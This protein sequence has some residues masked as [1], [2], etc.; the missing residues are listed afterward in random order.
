MRERV[1]IICLTVIVWGGVARAADRNAKGESVVE[2][3]FT[4]PIF[5]SPSSSSPVP[6][7]SNQTT[8]PKP[9]APES[10][11]VPRSFFDTAAANDPFAIP[12]STQCL[13]QRVN[14]LCRCPLDC[15]TWFS[16]EWLIG[17][18]RGVSLVPVIT[19]GPA[20]AG[21]LAGAVGQPTTF[22]LFGGKQVLN[23]WRSG[24]RVELGVWFDPDHRSGVSVRFY[25]L[26]SERE[27]FTALPNG[28]EVV[29]VPHFV[30]VGSSATQIP[31]FVGFPGV[32]SGTATASAQTTFTGGD[33]NYRHLLDGDDGHR[34]ELLVGYR[35]LYLSDQLGATFTAVPM[36]LNSSLATRLV[37]GDSLH[38]HNDFYGPQLG[39]CASTAWNRFTLEAHATTALGVTV[40]DLDFTRART[41]NGGSALVGIP[42]TGT[43]PFAANRIPLGAIATNGTLTYFG[44][45]AEGGVRLNW[46][47][48]DRVRL[49]GGYSFIYW[50]DV[51]RA[52][53]MFTGSSVL[54]AHSVDSVT[55]LLS[56]GLE[57]R[58]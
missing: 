17:S 39:L 50:N 18:T 40:S 34:I 13:P 37:G 41:L 35:Q 33:L 52:P 31:V 27:R 28:T 10:I 53:E 2:D 48:T 19:T 24:L 21:V 44:V 23:D 20:S 46:S 54:R 43:S 47:A 49:M 14:E 42:G 32:T 12:S 8:P 11:T 15:S 51:R 16:A 6:P 56:A 26:F 45:V 58:Y 7:K 57:V 4:D 5:N 9:D 25:S 3:P 22:P 1:W 30:P 36:G 55:H 38:T 29:D